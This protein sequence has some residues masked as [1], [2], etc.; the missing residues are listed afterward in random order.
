MITSPSSLSTTRSTPWV[1]G[2]CGPML[3][4]IKRSPVWSATSSSMVSV[5]IDG[6]SALKTAPASYGAAI[7]E[8][9]AMG[10]DSVL[11]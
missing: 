6:A 10:G 2:C 7:R 3:R 11:I 5:P 9:G 8:S 1:L 4:V